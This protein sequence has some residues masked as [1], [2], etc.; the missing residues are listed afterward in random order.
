MSHRV[1]SLVVIPEVAAGGAVLVVPART[2]CQLKPDMN[3]LQLSVCVCDFVCVSLSVHAGVQ[4]GLIRG[5]NCISTRA[6][7]K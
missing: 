3:S 7:P 4:L 2:S 1:S 5:E 6:V